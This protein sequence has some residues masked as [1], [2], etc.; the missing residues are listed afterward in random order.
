[1]IFFGL[2]DKKFVFLMHV[3]EDQ[4]FPELKIVY[5]IEKCLK[6]LQTTAKRDIFSLFEIKIS[7]KNNKERTK[8][9]NT[10]KSTF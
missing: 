6:L 10:L 2:R 7:K 1:M 3:R 5:F 8:N 4:N 9:L